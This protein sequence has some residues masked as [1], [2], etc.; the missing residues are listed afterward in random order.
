MTLNRLA[1]NLSNLLKNITNDFKIHSFYK[2]LQESLYCNFIFSTC[3]D[4]LQA[5]Y[6]SKFYSTSDKTTTIFLCT[7]KHQGP[8]S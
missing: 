8:L 4:L 6:F 1:K 2:G 7:P 5:A 3:K